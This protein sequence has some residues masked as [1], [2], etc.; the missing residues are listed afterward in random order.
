MVPVFVIGKVFSLESVSVRL[1]R[2]WMY[3]FM[4][5]CMR[6]MPGCVS[7]ALWPH[8]SCHTFSSQRHFHLQRL[9]LVGI[10]RLFAIAHALA[11]PVLESVELFVDVHRGGMIDKS[12]R[13][14]VLIDE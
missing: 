5:L 6:S 14:T 2:D 10:R 11:S 8:V 9:E 7:Q 1:E 12:L 3:V 4:L 13:L